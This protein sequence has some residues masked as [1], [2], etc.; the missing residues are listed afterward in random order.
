MIK[1]NTFDSYNKRFIGINLKN[2]RTSYKLTKIDVAKIIGK[3]VSGYDHYES[4]LR[5]IG[6]SDLITLS[7]FY[8]VSLDVICANPFS[9]KSETVLSFLGFKKDGEEVIE[10]RPYMLSTIFD[11]VICYEEDEE[12]FIFFWKTNAH[13]EGHLMLF[14]YYDKT[15]VSKVFFNGKGGGHFY[16]NGNPKY[17]N[18][19]HSENILF[20]GVL[21]AK[22]DKKLVVDNFFRP[23]F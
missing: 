7:G 17:F 1:K 22:L 12:N 15:Y 3:S 19:A 6:I 2:L 5:D 10:T 14:H 8:N 23:H 13:N 20:R 16:I 9:H 4:G 21:M 18:K 11:D